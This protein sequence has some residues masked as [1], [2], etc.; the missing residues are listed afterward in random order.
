MGFKAVE[1]KVQ[2]K[3]KL[4]ARMFEGLS[5]F[6]I[7]KENLIVCFQLLERELQYFLP[8]RRALCWGT[9]AC[10]A[11]PPPLQK[12]NQLPDSSRTELT[13]NLSSLW[14]ELLE[15]PWPGISSSTCFIPP[16]RCAPVH[17][18]AVAR[19]PTRSRSSHS[20][21]FASSVPCRSARRS[22][23][24]GWSDTDGAEVRWEQP[25]RFHMLQHPR[26]QPAEPT[27]GPAL[28]VS[29]GTIS[30]L[31]QL[32]YALGRVVVKK[33]SR[34]DMGRALWESPIDFIKELGSGFRSDFHLTIRSPI[35][36]ALALAS[37]QL[38]ERGQ[39][40]LFR[41]QLTELLLQP[42]FASRM[43][44]D[45]QGQNVF[46]LSRIKRDLCSAVPHHMK[47]LPYY[48][49]DQPVIGYCQAH[50][51]L[52]VNKGY[53]TMSRE[54]AETTNLELSRDH[55]F[56]ATIARKAFPLLFIQLFGE[57]WLRSEREDG[58]AHQAPS[59]HQ[60]VLLKRSRYG[61]FA[62]DGIF[63][64]IAVC[65]SAASRRAPKE[66]CRL[67]EVS[68]IGQKRKRVIPNSVVAEPLCICKAALTSEAAG[69]A[70]EEGCKRAEHQVWD[71]LAKAA[72]LR[73]TGLRQ[74]FACRLPAGTLLKAEV[75]AT[76]FAAEDG[77]LRK[78]STEVVYTQGELRVLHLPGAEMNVMAARAVL[79]KRNECVTGNC[80]RDECLQNRRVGR[81]C[82]IASVPLLKRVEGGAGRSTAVV[83]E[84]SARVPFH[85]YPEKWQ[86]GG[87]EELMCTYPY[88]KISQ[89][90]KRYRVIQ[91]AVLKYMYWTSSPIYL[92]AVG[93]L[94][95]MVMISELV[96]KLVEIW[97]IS[98]KYSNVKSIPYRREMLL[99]MLHLTCPP[100]TR[101]QDS[102]EKCFCNI[103][104]MMENQEGRW[105]KIWK[106][107]ADKAFAVQLAETGAPSGPLK[108]GL[109]LKREQAVSKRTSRFNAAVDVG[110]E[111]SPRKALVLRKAPSTF[112][113]RVNL[114]LWLC[115]AKNL[116][117]VFSM[118]VSE[119]RAG[120]L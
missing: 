77:S 75:L 83:T 38:V 67:A 48:S 53:D 9:A 45:Q 24:H 102:E 110:S 70:V 12:E 78:L 87:S 35:M 106:T 104:S 93:F 114:A 40:G 63:M 44:T 91:L 33:G 47:T 42:S 6:S 118:K 88:L 105:Q 39:R 52:H 50:K 80:P 62:Y 27:A 65:L 34:H 74:K 60:I 29:S 49:Y 15:K 21:N 86:S 71:V 103:F 46:A 25:S 37:W 17:N 57:K 96:Y 7:G 85:W 95:T 20:H 100:L 19:R 43:L 59:K 2:K 107:W 28:V 23:E 16:A 90:L 76:G 5:L 117:L 99:M 113:L 94:A 82:C 41:E 3:R 81:S 101:R 22:S 54:Q 26:Q 68:K 32:L 55:S 98:L 10:G 115:A 111:F 116:A 72:S 89:E 13:A 79:P 120:E 31:E 61:M 109:L 11:C 108:Y 30:E 66:S 112:K 14:V 56:I 4:W 51:P 8:E 84:G 92:F 119:C 36:T 58:A 18:L 69:P 64:L 1:S 73:A 97:L